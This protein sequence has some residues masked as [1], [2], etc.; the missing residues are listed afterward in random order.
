LTGQ[1]NYKGQRYSLTYTYDDA[2][3]THNTSVTDSFGYVSRG[4]YNLKYGKVVKTTDINNNPLDYTYDQFGR[5]ATIVGPYQTGTGLDTIYFEYHP[6]A[7]IPWAL[8]RH[9]DV[10]RDIKVPIETVLFTDGL[11]RVLQTK[12]DATVFMGES[13][14]AKDVMTV[15]GRITF[16]FLGRSI[17]QYYPITESLGDQG[18]FNTSVDS[19][20]P[21]VTVYDVMDRTI[22]TTIPD[23][24][25]S[26][27]AY[28]F[29]LD[30]T[31]QTQ[32]LTRVTDANGIAKETYKDVRGVITAVKEFNDFGSQIL[33]TSYQYD[34]LKQ[35]VQVLDDQNNLT[36]VSYDNLGRRTHIDNPDMGL[37]ETVYDLA[38][39]VRQKITANLRLEGKAILYEY[40]YNRLMSITYPSRVDEKGKTL[41]PSIDVAYT[42]GAPGAA[43]NRA[44]RIITV[45]DQSGMEERFY[46]KLGETLKTIKT[47]A[48]DTQGASVNS[49][50]IYTTEYVYDTWNRLQSLIYPDGE[51]LTNQYD[52]GGLIKAAKGKKAKH[53]YTYL[54]RLEYDK[55]GQRQFVK[56]GNK[57]YSQYSYNPLNR[58]LATLQT[59]KVDE[60]TGLEVLFQDLTYQYDPVGNI[61][62]QSNLAAVESPSQL[63]G[64]TH[65][66]YEY[67]DLYR[68]VHAQGTFDYQPSKQHR[69]QLAMLYDSIHNITAKNQLHTLRQPSGTL[70]TQKK[71]TY[72]WQYAYDGSQPHAPTHIGER[73]F[74]YDA[75][76]NQTGWEHDQNGTRRTQVWD[77]ENRI[78]SIADNGHTKTYKYN[79]AGERVMKV[80]PQGET[81]YVNQFFSMRNRSVGTKHVYA[82]K[83]RLVSKLVK[84]E[85]TSVEAQNGKA[86]KTKANK[87]PSEAKWQYFYHPDH[88]GSSAYVSDAKGKLYQHLEYFPF[89]ETFVE[90]SSN[91]QRTPYLFTGKELDEETGL[92]YFGARYYDPRTSVWQSPD[93][94]L[95]NYL[96]DISEPNRRLLGMGGIFNSY[97]LSVYHYSAHNPVKYKD[98]DGNFFDIVWDVAN[99][100]MGVA[101]FAGNVATGNFAGA[102]LDAAGIVADT[103]AAVIPGVP[104]GA[105]TAIKAARA[106]DKAVDVVKNVAKSGDDIVE[107]VAKHGDDVATKIT[108][109]YKRPNNA[110]T[111]AQRASVQGKPC[112]DCGKITP[113]QVADHKKPLVKEY[114]ETGTIDTQK[115]RSLDAVQPQCPTCSAK[116]GAEMSQYSKQMKKDLDL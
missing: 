27:T 49:P 65:F 31:G 40:D 95:A 29:G 63:G 69:Y 80:G 106:A 4:E 107:A 50:E 21:T 90:Q 36:S 62:G 82:G 54:K 71:T 81:V 59:G 114:Y 111:A 76:G 64:A 110:T 3:H 75:N 1:T 74:S 5:V 37:T 41:F 56:L 48:S 42:Y 19:I 38:S 99:I 68:L 92:Y 57:V 30:R 13:R 91:T 11:K 39:N 94:I 52:S 10:Y 102:A 86:G 43:F 23:K 34:P 2:V 61:L 16:D 47:V 115:M 44:N 100:A 28:G 58:R 17:E 103:T 113:K 116:Q 79:D 88:L 24:T 25:L 84:Q 70:V 85:N 60:E 15:S 45:T 96:P 97:N 101:S 53:R 8:T 14:P 73:T 46:G 78:Q 12:K 109:P 77:A 108:K 83:A 7:K 20:Q 6:E 33:W 87:S 98:A 55:F 51:V 35:I 89:G 26:L 104:G 66:Q 105:G 93:P 72:D 22:R 112:V 18:V 32:F 67:D 9:I